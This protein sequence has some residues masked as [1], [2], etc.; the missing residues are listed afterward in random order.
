MQVSDETSYSDRRS[1]R[2]HLQVLCLSEHLLCS[3]P[4]RRT[5]G[6][7][8]DVDDPKAG[9]TVGR[10]KFD[11]D[12]VDKAAVRDGRVER[13]DVADRGRDRVGAFAGREGL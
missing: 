5:N 4:A 6:R 10:V 11:K 7:R 1:R 12:G 8:I 13:G 3:S 2:A 9:V